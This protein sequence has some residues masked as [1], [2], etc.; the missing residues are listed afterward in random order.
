MNEFLISM[1]F[2][3][4]FTF[5]KGLKGPKN[6]EKYRAVLLKLYKAIGAAY[7]DDPEFT[8]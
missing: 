1:A 7:A 3:T 8:G 6:R 4:L 2:S 5:L